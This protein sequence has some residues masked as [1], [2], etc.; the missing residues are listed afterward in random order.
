MENK[1]VA[2]KSGFKDATIED[3]MVPPA[4]VHKQCKQASHY[5]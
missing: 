1:S 3:T 5:L 4:V 2:Q